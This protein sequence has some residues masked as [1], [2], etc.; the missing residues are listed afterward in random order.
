MT[1]STIDDQCRVLILARIISHT[2]LAAAMLL[3]G[4]AAPP[5][6]LAQPSVAPALQANLAQPPGQI[7]ASLV[8]I[9]V[10]F[11]D[12]TSAELPVEKFERY[13]KT[14][15]IW[16]TDTETG[17]PATFTG[18]APGYGITARGSTSIK[19][20]IYGQGIFMA[21]PRTGQCILPKDL[22]LHLPQLKPSHHGGQPI[23]REDDPNQWEFYRAYTIE[24]PPSYVSYRFAFGI[25]SDRLQP[26]DK[27]CLREMTADQY[28]R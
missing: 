19:K 26:D 13:F 23:Y 1:R 6:P 5:K 7:D 20:V 3:N 28:F 8:S 14:K 21:F 11:A 12:L 16:K 24:T 27:Q 2:L 22:L 9:L 18:S 25:N 10:K 4:C 17:L 15:G